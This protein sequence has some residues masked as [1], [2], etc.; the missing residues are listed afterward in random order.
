MLCVTKEAAVILD[1][2][3]NSSD[4][5]EKKLTILSSGTGCGSPVLKVEMREPLEDDVTKNI[6][7]YDF[8]IRTSVQRYLEDA[9]L[10]IEDTYW[11]KKLRIHTV[12]GCRE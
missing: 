8:H 4:S 7:G 3:K 10:A 5:P 11:G 6:D 9:E 1:E 12:Y 2:I